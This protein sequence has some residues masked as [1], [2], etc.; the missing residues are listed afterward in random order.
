MLMQIERVNRFVAW[1]GFL[2]FHMVRLTLAQ[3]QMNYH[4]SQCG[5]W[6]QEK[7]DT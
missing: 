1:F 5:H 2:N 4:V 3:A 6:N 7:A